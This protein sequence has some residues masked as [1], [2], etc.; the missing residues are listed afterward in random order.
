MEVAL[1]LFIKSVVAF[2]GATA[3]MTLVAGAVVNAFR[4]FQPSKEHTDETG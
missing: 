1:C 4:L 2:V 3:L